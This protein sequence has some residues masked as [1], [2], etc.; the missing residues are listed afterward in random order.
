MTF[1]FQV[2]RSPSAVVW[3]NKAAY[4]FEPMPEAGPLNCMGIFRKMLKILAS[5]G[6][7]HVQPV[8]NFIE[9]TET[10]TWCSW[11]QLETARACGRNHDVVL[12]KWPI[13][14]RRWVCSWTPFVRSLKFQLWTW[15]EVL[16]HHEFFCSDFRNL[17][18]TSYLCILPR[19]RRGNGRADM[20]R[21][22]GNQRQ[23]LFSLNI[24][25]HLLRAMY[26][27]VS[28]W[29]RSNM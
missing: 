4:G 14:C 3:S 1:Q 21:T 10:A 19:S 20:A 27:N 11:I 12:S 22:W 15:Y 16:K 18:N 28:G 13:H 26:S 29:I 17:P 23:L 2:E 7:T 5:H 8:Q 24:P 6:H 25:E 9:I